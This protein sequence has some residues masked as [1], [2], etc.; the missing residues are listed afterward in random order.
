MD[1]EF[2]LHRFKKKKGQ[3]GS[4]LHGSGKLVEE[5]SEG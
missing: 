1:A 3:E 5:K 2:F 4:A